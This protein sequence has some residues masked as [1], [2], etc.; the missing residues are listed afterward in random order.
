MVRAWTVRA[1]REGER[2]SVALEEGLVI[3]GWEEVNQDLSE[4]RDRE[5]L[6]AL[7]LDIYEDYSPQVIANWTGQLWRFRE[8]IAIGD[9][10]V[11]PVTRSGRRRLAVGTV[12]GPYH[13]RATSAPGFRHTR[14][15]EWKR[16]DI[17]RD[18]V[19]PDLR[20]SMGSLLTV[21][22]LSRNNAAQRISAL[23]EQGVDPGPSESTDDRP[24]IA[25]PQLLEELVAQSLDDGEP[26][27]LTVRELLSIWGHTRR[28]PSVVQQIHGELEQRGLSTKPPFTDGNINSKITIVPVGTEPSAGVPVPKVTE[29]P[30]EPSPEDRPV[31]WLV[32]QLPSAET[33]LAWVRPDDELSTA[34]TRMAIDNFSQLP[35]LDDEGRLLGA[36]SWESIGIAYLSN[37]APT[38]EHN[39]AKL[40]PERAI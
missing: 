27:T 25:S 39:T 17:D 6:R 13:Y 21:F 33:Q 29:L 7:L 31:T 35:V 2:E 34:T 23:V 30:D 3:A 9:L 8:E 16:S 5:Q 4:I 14:P 32:K 12:T 15:V 22:E 38:L 10:V 19:Q 18:A 40:R 28:W 26:V 36:V 1:G 11:M 24:S 37:R 20:D